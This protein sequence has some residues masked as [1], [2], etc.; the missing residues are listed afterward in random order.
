MKQK[1]GDTSR[2]PEDV[3]YIPEVVINGISLPAVKTAMEAGIKAVLNIKG[4]SKIS[5]GN[6]GGRLGE[7]QI[8]LHE[9]SL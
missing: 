9:L 7:Y 5:A 6:Y 1:L 8:H 2:V 3:N 4:V